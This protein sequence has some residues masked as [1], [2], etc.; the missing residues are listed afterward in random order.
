MSTSLSVRKAFLLSFIYAHCPNQ[1]SFTLMCDPESEY[2]NTTKT[3][4]GRDTGGN[5]DNENWDHL[6][7]I[8]GTRDHRAKNGWDQGPKDKK[9]LGPGTIAPPHS[10]SPLWKM[11]L[12]RFILVIGTCHFSCRRGKGWAALQTSFWALP[13]CRRY[14]IK[15]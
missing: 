11:Y 5:G 2:M 3:G 9:W 13:M 7:K 6:T 8:A 1:L 12:K 4:M 10:E 15:V 14:T